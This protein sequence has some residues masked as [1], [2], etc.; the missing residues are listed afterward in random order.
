VAAFDERRGLWARITHFFRRQ[1]NHLVGVQLELCSGREGDDSYVVVRGAEA[2]N[3]IDVLL[4]TFGNDPDDPWAKASNVV[5][6]E[7]DDAPPT[8]EQQ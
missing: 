7:T 5:W 1:D 8:E 6:V 2:V 3:M 4:H